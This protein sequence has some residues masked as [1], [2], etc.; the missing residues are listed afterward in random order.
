MDAAREE[1][2]ALLTREE[3]K[4]LS[5]SRGELSRSINV[6]EFCAAEGRRQNGETIASEL[7]N[8]FAYTIKQPHG[9]VACVTAMEFPSRDPSVE[10]RSGSGCRQYCCF[11]T[12][13]VDAGN[14]FAN[15]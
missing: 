12:G 8:N 5:E 3:G 14:G 10:D 1:L 9:V 2:A 11:Q 15:C 13:N 7:P 6:V 4:T